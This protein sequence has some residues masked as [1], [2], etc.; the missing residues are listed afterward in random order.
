MNRG[1]CSCSALL[2][3]VALHTI[4]GSIGAVREGWEWTW[5]WY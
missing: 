5:T 4:V 1:G 3:V 2:S